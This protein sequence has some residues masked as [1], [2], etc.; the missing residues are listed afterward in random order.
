MNR[1]GK[2]GFSDNPQNRNNKGAP[3][4]GESWKDI[5][6]HVTSMTAEEA[7]R[8]YGKIARDFKQYGKVTLR[9]LMVV[10]GVHAFLSEPNASLWNAIMDRDEGKV[11]QPINVSKLSDEELLALINGES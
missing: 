9:E 11:T 4:R 7:A 6:H 1:T 10:R 2:G 3:P 8:T 5:I